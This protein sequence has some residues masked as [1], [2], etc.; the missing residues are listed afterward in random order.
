MD[1]RVSTA[2]NTISN[3]HNI[4][5]LYI[6]Q[7]KR[8][9]DAPNGNVAVILQ[10]NSVQVKIERAISEVHKYGTLRVD[11]HRGVQSTLHNIFAKAAKLIPQ[12]LSILRK[13][14]ST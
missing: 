9:Q 6:P 14:D 7:P 10:S 13:E 2:I 5:L 8:L 12:K 1:G 4:A 3:Y 11:A